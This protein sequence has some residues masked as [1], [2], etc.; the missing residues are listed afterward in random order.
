MLEVEDVEDVACTLDDIE[1]TDRS[2]CLVQRGWCEG[3]GEKGQESLS[4]VQAVQGCGEYLAPL[5]GPG[6]VTLRARSVQNRK[7]IWRRPKY[8]QVS[9]LQTPATPDS[10][11]SAEKTLLYRYV[12]DHTDRLLHEYSRSGQQPSSLCN[13]DFTLISLL[14]R[15]G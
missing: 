2:R 8:R 3:R 5:F 4:S 10:T 11:R 7:Q 9:R 6:L 13:C 12:Q 15:L 14:S 1:A